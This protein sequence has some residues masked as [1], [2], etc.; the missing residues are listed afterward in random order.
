V[1]EH[2]EGLLYEVAKN[3]PAEFNRASK[4][5][6]RDGTVGP[7]PTW[8]LNDLLQTARELGIVGEDVVKFG[9]AVRDFRNYIH[10]QQQVREQFRP[11]QIT[12]QIAR[13][14]LAAALDDLSQTATASQTRPN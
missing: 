12:A 2:L 5:P 1:R 11:R 14:V 10:P 3:H 6:R 9:H 8:T 7:L 4:A 13:Q